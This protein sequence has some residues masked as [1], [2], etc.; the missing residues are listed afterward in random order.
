[1]VVGLFFKMFE[2]FVGQTCAV[3]KPASPRR[4]TD[5]LDAFVPFWRDYCQWTALHEQ[6][7]TIYPRAASESSDGGGR[8]TTPRESEACRPTPKIILFIST[9]ANET[10]GLWV[11]LF[12]DA[13]IDD[14]FMGGFCSIFKICIRQSWNDPG[15]EPQALSPEPALLILRMVLWCIR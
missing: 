6:I 15:A 5:T 8:T 14:T 1:M 11:R 7:I 12:P 10:P 4:Q 2:D 13:D 9:H 3:P